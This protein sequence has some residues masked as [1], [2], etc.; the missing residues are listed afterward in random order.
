MAWLEIDGG[1]IVGVHSERCVSELEWVEFD[2]EANPGDGWVDGKLIPAQEDIAP[3]DLRRRQARAH[4][5]E[6]YPEWRQL[7]VLRAGD[8]EA[9]ATMGKFIDAC[10]NWSNDPAADPADLAAIQ[11]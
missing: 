8:S 1:T 11:P 6:Y 9:I 4:I 7:N 3:E 5:L 10:R 2:G